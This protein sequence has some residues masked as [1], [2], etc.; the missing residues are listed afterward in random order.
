MQNFA[1][2][3]NAVKMQKKKI[4]NLIGSDRVPVY[5]AFMNFNS[6]VGNTKYLNLHQ[7]KKY[8]CK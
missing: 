1:I 3:S 8:I 2:Q 4:C 7:P 6:L 5:Y